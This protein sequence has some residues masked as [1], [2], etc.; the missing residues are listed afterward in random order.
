[1]RYVLN[2]LPRA[3]RDIRRAMSWITQHISPL[4]AARWHTR[5]IQAVSSLESKPDRCPEAD[6]AASVGINLR[7][8]ISGRR[9]HVY[10]ILFSIDG[11]EVTVHRILHA[12]RDYVD[13]DDL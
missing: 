3:T 5:I 13:A 7:C 8:L 2:I 4:S 6:E 11:I 9:P 10:R 1:M 12:A